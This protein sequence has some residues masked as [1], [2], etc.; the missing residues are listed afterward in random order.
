MSTC[1]FL[2][3]PAAV[4]DAAWRG[5]GVYDVLDNLAPISAV[6]DSGG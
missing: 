1:G 4:V 6:T 2:H 3:I 5:V